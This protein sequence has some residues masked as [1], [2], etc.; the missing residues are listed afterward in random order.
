MFEQ[1]ILSE[2]KGRRRWTV[3]LAF[4]GQSVMLGALIAIP[5][6]SVQQLPLADLTSVLIAPAP[7]PPPPPPPAAAP[8]PRA[9]RVEPRRF[10][11]SAVYEPH[12]V[13]K[14]VAVIS[15]LPQVPAA[16]STVDGVPGGVP[17]G[18]VGGVLGGIL[19]GVPSVAPPPPPPPPPAEAAAVQAPAAPAILRVGGQVQAA[20]AISAPPPVYPALAKTARISGAVKLDAVIGV[21]GHIENL[22]V[23]SGPPLLI[24]AAMNAVKQWTYRPTYL[25]GKPF[26][27]ETQIV[28]TFTLG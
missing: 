20:L 9:V 12:V 16:A 27:V 19:G 28:V 14:T 21:D 18:Q 13:P 11:M 4:A 7:P 24:E 17:G 25:N 1:M 8:A 10:N 6:L 15:D 3:V 2:P 23:M 5:L 22:K 26:K